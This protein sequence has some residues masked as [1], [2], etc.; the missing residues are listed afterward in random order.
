[1]YISVKFNSWQSCS[2]CGCP[3]GLSGVSRNTLA[4]VCMGKEILLI[5]SR[6]QAWTHGDPGWGVWPWSIPI[7]HLNSLPPSCP[8]CAHKFPLPPSRLLHREACSTNGEGK[9]RLFSSAIG[10]YQMILGFFKSH[11]LWRLYG[12]DLKSLCAYELCK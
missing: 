7:L 6:G 12:C 3:L 4:I 1:M 5:C 2:S 10:L 8:S 11:W 9:V